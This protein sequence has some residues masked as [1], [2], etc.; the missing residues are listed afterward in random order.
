VCETADRVVVLYAGARAEEAGI[1]QL[2][3]APRHPYTQGLMAS[4]P[5]RALLAGSAARLAEIPGAVPAPDQLPAGCAFTNRCSRA[6]GPCADAAPP[7]H[8]GAEGHVIACF[9]PAPGA[10]P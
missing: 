6:I 9:N 1:E 5:R 4:I 8:Q 10:L 2:F 3:R 7:L